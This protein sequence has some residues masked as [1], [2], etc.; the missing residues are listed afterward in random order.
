MTPSLPTTTQ[1]LVDFDTAAR[2]LLPALERLEQLL[3]GEIEALTAGDLDALSRHT[4]DKRRQL[5]ELEAEVSRLQVPGRQGDLRSVAWQEMLAR[6]ARCHE[7]NQAIGATLSTQ[8]RQNA[9]LLSLLGHAPAAAGYGPAG[10]PRAVLAGQ[11]RPL[12]LG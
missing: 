7:L 11:G 5:R 1:A 3:D 4:R 8:L 2:R 9:D 10:K 12:A 6:L